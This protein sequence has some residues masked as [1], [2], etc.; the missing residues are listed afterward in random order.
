MIGTEVQQHEI[1]EKAKDWFRDVLAKNH[2]QNTQKLSNPK[3]FNIN[4]F[5]VTYLA[6]FLTGNASAESIARALIYPRVLG[7]SITTSFGQNLQKFTGDVLGAFGSTTAGID[8][9]FVDHLDGQKKYCQLKA[10]P[11]TINKDDVATVQHHFTAIRNLART[12]NLRIGVNDL[13]VGV[14]YGEPEQLSAHYKKIESLHHHPVIIG[15]D[16]WNRLTGNPDFYFALIRSFTEVAK[17]ADSSLL[18]EETIKKLAASEAIQ[19]I[20]S[21]S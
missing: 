16:F 12:N 18:L 4:P 8:I 21:M 10:G 9:E 14:L 6:N 20:A 11:N 1:L 15:R 13:V 7:Q 2:I 5:L 17:D 3:A 19:K